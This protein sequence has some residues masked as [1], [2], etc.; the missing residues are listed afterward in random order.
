MIQNGGKMRHHLVSIVLLMV[1][2]I[3][4]V[5]FT[6]PVEIA[7]SDQNFLDQDGF[8]DDVNSDGNL[9]VIFYDQDGPYWAEDTDGDSIP[10]TKHYVGHFTNNFYSLDYVDMN[11]DGTEEIIAKFDGDHNLYIFY[12]NGTGDFS[13]NNM[14]ALETSIGNFGM[15]LIHDFN[16]DGIQDIYTCDGDSVKY[17]SRTQTTAPFNSIALPYGTIQDK[18]DRYCSLADL[19]NDSYMDVVGFAGYNEPYNWREFDPNTNSFIYHQLPI[20]FMG[21]N[22]GITPID[23]NSDGLTDLLVY[24]DSLNA[25]QMFENDE[26]QSFSNSS[27]LF[28]NLDS[29]YDIY[30]YDLN[31][32][33]RDDLIILYYGEKAGIYVN[34]G[35]GFIFDCNLYG[36]GGNLWFKDFDGDEY[37]EIVTEP[38]T[39]IF[40]VY[41]NNNG[42]IDNEN[43]RVSSF[44]NTD[45]ISL[46]IHDD[47]FFLGCRHRYNL[48]YLMLED[49]M[50]VHSN[51][52]TPGIATVS[53]AAFADVDGDG[54][55][56][57]AYATYTDDDTK[58]L[59][60]SLNGQNII[61][62]DSNYR[63]G[64]ELMFVDLDFDG[65]MDLIDIRNENTHLF[66]NENGTLVD[67]VVVNTDNLF[68]RNTCKYVD[69]DNDGIRDI[70]Y[71]GSNDQ[72]FWIKNNGLFSFGLSEW[73][74]DI[75]SDIIAFDDLNLDGRIDMIVK[76]DSSRNNLLIRYGEGSNSSFSFSQVPDTLFFPGYIY[77]IELG[78]FNNDGV[79]DIAVNNFHYGEIVWESLID[80]ALNPVDSTNWEIVTLAHIPDNIV[81][82]SSGDVDQNGTDDIVYLDNVTG[83][84]YILYNNIHTGI[85]KHDLSFCNTQLYANYPNPFNPETN[86]KYSMAKAGS[87]NL[88]IYNIKGQKV[89]TLINDHVES[90]EH[91]IIWNGKDEKDSDVSSGVYFYRLKTADGVQ[92][93]KMLLLK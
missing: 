77:S 42:N 43:I 70:V 55:L 29:V 58:A 44:R 25:I 22:S 13:M 59:I 24:S 11:N 52:L 23:V 62:D 54:Q 14:D 38:D 32:D 7:N 49:S 33:A 5:D 74:A 21:E 69:M 2:N 78:D 41:K 79:K 81:R 19:N 6:G 3:W 51:F 84:M 85:R 72:L 64:R 92:N 91:S 10:D 80:V 65:D 53:D 8:V 40:R 35:T 26:N 73:I 61:L 75:S 17:F 36:T 57:C 48:N 12:G 15:I 37:K 76:D 9:D 39:Y 50:F 66:S 68:Y 63:G 30:K 90:G 83:E 20:R 87:A 34:N 31:Q 46:I 56:D 93:R 67:S 4:A 86:I 89:K 18:Y 82:M 88:T 27:I 16:Q 47:R 28:N 45:E 1:C 60:L 71:T